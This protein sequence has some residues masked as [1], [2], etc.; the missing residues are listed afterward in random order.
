[1]PIYEY[2]CPA[3]KEPFEELVRSFDA[4]VACPACGEPDAERRLSVFAPSPRGAPQPDY[5]RL[6]RPR[7]AGG[8][9]GG[10]CGHA[11]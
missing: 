3:C 6:A 11:H 8:C 7:A 1:V 9:C 4:P 10:A 5:S 2:T